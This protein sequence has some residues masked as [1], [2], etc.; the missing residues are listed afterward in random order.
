MTENHS[1]G[2][3]VINLEAVRKAHQARKVRGAVDATDDKKLSKNEGFTSGL[4]NSITLERGLVIAHDIVH[5]YST[6][7]ALLRAFIERRNRES[8][9]ESEEFHEALTERRR[10]VAGYSPDQLKALLALYRKNPPSCKEVYIVP[11][12]EE[13]L[14]RFQPQAEEA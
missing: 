14:C 6:P 3:E 8:S 5:K 7:G 12:A 9:R 11:A 13:F 4:A 1:A 10:K 2:A